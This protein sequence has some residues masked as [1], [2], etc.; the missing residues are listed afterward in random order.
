MDGAGLTTRHWTAGTL[1]GDAADGVQAKAAWS[2][3]DTLVLT[4]GE[5]AVTTMRLDPNPG[6][7]ER[8]LSVP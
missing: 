6:K 4:T 7:P 2:R 3:P 1:N 5:G 8:E